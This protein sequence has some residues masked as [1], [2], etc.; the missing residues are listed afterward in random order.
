MYHLFQF[1]VAHEA[2]DLAVVIA[3]AAV[4]GDLLRARVAGPEL[5]ADDDVRHVGGFGGVAEP[6]DDELLAGDCGVELHGGGV[7]LDIGG[8]GGDVGGVI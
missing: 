2:G 7:A 8:R 6:L 4:L 5:W 3:E 1:R